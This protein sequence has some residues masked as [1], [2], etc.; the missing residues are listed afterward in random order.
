MCLHQELSRWHTHIGPVVAYSWYN[1]VFLRRTGENVRD[2]R[3]HG[4][5]LPSPWGQG[6][7]ILHVTSQ[8]QAGEGTS[9]TLIRRALQFLHPPRDFRCAFLFCVE[10]V[11]WLV[12]SREVT[13]FSD[14]GE[15]R[16]I[17]KGDAN[18]TQ[19]A[20]LQSVKWYVPVFDEVKMAITCCKPM[21]LV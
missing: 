11:S 1:A 2:R 4:T 20:L 16:C 10:V 13:P 9:P 19:R 6:N 12:E 17:L 7:H 18:G 5:P 15:S 21:P 8:L 14:K 3:A